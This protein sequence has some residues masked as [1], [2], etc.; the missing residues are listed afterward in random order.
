MDQINKLTVEMRF[1]KFLDTFWP[2]PPAKSPR[3]PVNALLQHSFERYEIWKKA[4][5]LAQA[6]WYALL[7]TIF[8]PLRV[9]TPS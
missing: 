2:Q 1:S 4:P 8:S 3:Y 7:R 9:L 5:A 6:V